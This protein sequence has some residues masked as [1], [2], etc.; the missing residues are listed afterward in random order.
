[1]R[2]SSILWLAC[3]LMAGTRGFAQKITFN[4]RNVP[5]QKAFTAIT[6][7]TGYV[8]FCDR[9]L[10]A[11]APQVTIAAKDMVLTD[12]LVA[13]L[14]GSGLEYSI[15]GRMITIVRTTKSI[16]DTLHELEGRVTN[17][18][19]QP[20]GSANVI[21][22]RTG[23]G[24]E[25]DPA[26]K[27]SLNGFGLKTSDVLLVSYVGY[28]TLTVPVKGRANLVLILEPATNEL[29]KVVVQAYGNTTQRLATGDIGTVTS[30]EIARQ[31]VMNPLEALQGQV[32]GAV[33]T[34][35]TGYASGV[36]KLEIR[37]RNTINPGFPSD[38][39]YIIDGVP[40]SVSEVSN[41]ASYA[42]GSPGFD[43]VGMSPAGGQSPLF[44]LN[45]LDI[46]SISV[47]KDADATAIYG[48]RGA[49]GVVLITTKKGKAGRTRFDFSAYQGMMEVPRHYD[50][51]DTRQY[52]SIRREA[53]NNDVLPVNLNNAPDLVAWDT[54]RYTDWQRFI[55]GNMGK[56]QDAEAS[57]SGGDDRTTFRVG[58]NYHLVRD[59]LN[60]SGDNVRT[61]LNFNLTH[62]LINERLT[63]SLTGT[64]S[65]VSIN[66]I[67]V[68]NAVT[69]GP[70]APAVFDKNGNL[71]FAGWEPL[72]GYFPFGSLLQ[73][74]TAVTNFLNGNLSVDYVVVRG[75]DVKLSLGYNNAVNKQTYLTPM[76]S[77]DPLLNQLGQAQFGYGFFHNVIAEPQ[78]SYSTLLSKGKL[79]ALLG[80]TTQTN[81]TEGLTD[82]GLGYNN[83][84]LLGSISNAPS[85]LIFDG[86][87]EYRY[88]GAFARVN[89][90]WEDEFILNLNGRRDGSS[91]FA[92]GRQ[93]GN[94]WSVG[95]AWIFTEEAWAA[96]A[97]P[98]LSFGKF[99]GSYGLTGGDQIQPYQYMSKWSYGGY[100]Y[101]G[102]LP[103]TPLSHTDSLLHWQ[104]NRKLEGALAL[105]FLK[106]RIQVEAAWYRDRCNDQLVS[107]PTPYF[108]GFN[109]V[110]AN[111]PAD[112][113]NTGWEFNIHA[114]ISTGKLHW[115]TSFR[116]GINRNKLLAY[117]N[118]DESPYVGSY[119]I[120]QSLNAVKL[121]QWTGINPQ[122]GFYTFADKNKDGQITIDY[123]G[124]PD[125][126]SWHDL[127]PRYD[128][129]WTN[130]FGYRRWELSCLFYFRKQLGRNVYANIQPPGTL[131]NNGPTATMNHWSKPGDQAE[132]ARLTT[133]PSDPS[134]NDFTYFSTGA[135]TDA[136][137]IRLQN[138]SLS[139][140][141]HTKSG[142]FKVYAQGQNLFI[143]THYDGIDPETQNFGGLPQSR[144]LTFGISCNL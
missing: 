126:R 49:N 19:G 44:S 33:V 22:A 53:L 57:L 12:F 83:D 77:L 11:S 87:S 131:P 24:T 139:Y 85:K 64:Y 68:A 6:D 121:L 79:E 10:L 142:T 114:A 129:G 41:S 78:L 37:G 122:T 52:V 141:L 15:E 125:D 136:S 97:L 23:Y 80:G 16:P 13:C 32:P 20:L 25:T 35:T 124:K 67:T 18:G 70:N 48:S 14:K 50:M 29:D 94:F 39:L 21:I 130:T 112:V 40:L 99:R 95:G 65:Y 133:N 135:Y 42:G 123:S 1:M 3:L 60:K 134:Y 143:L 76:A 81:Q 89:Y 38:P 62:H 107:F 84:A 72:D 127:S 96:K 90:N 137:F 54:T 71:N 5:L 106:D 140:T 102:V 59:I 138:A 61:G 4:G 116:V 75:L 144:T 92:P 115:N 100:P 36:I 28:K 2:L 82:L 27:F 86:S 111:S 104:V 109:N 91:K 56:V 101:N 74:Y 43:Q 58:A 108:T 51:L 110:T 128:G 132:F 7:Q 17:E 46:E 34:N 55:W 73:P 98:F 120:G 31:P 88:A 105:G 117:P 30:E 45:P 113:Q 47:L 119:A 26:G 8:V 118:F 66:T 69:L 9:T 103:L 93:F 63:L